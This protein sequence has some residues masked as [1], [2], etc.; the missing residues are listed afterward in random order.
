MGHLERVCGAL[1]SENRVQGPD[2]SAE[3]KVRV[4]EKKTRCD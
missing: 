2:N 3:N 1:E 4:K